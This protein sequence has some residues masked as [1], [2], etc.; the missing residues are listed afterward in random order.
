MKFFFAVAAGL[1]MVANAHYTFDRFVMPDGTIT[2]RWEYVRQHDSAFNSSRLPTKFKEPFD[3]TPYDEDFRCNYNAMDY[4]ERTKVVEIEAGST[5]GMRI[6]PQTGEYIFHQGPLQ[7]YMSKA[8]TGNVKEYDGSGDWFKISQQTT[9]WPGTLDSEAWCA[10]GVK[11]VNFTIPATLPAGE[12]LVRAEHIALHLANEGDVEFYYSCAQV[13]VTGD[14]EGVP[15]PLVSIPGLYHVDDPALN[16]FI[17]GKSK[18]PYTPGGK[19]W[20]G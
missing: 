17:W 9:C 2:G 1:G 4:A 20:A 8:P 16:F 15:T 18:Y 5:V 11:Q 3:V 12:Y 10:N 19:P 7:V 13:K 14:G 6:S